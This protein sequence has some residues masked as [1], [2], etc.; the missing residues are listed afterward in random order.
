M[1]CVSE[2]ELGILWI[3]SPGL[4][5]THVHKT[6]LCYRSLKNITPVVLE[7]FNSVVPLYKPA[8]PVVCA[9]GWRWELEPGPS[10][11]GTEPRITEYGI[12]WAGRDPVESWKVQLKEVNKS[13]TSNNCPLFS[14][15][16]IRRELA[17]KCNYKFSLPIITKYSSMLLTLFEWALLLDRR[18]SPPQR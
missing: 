6:L 16:L 15:E 3:S 1:W 2:A 8:S 5:E 14:P 4:S 12:S 7:L 11:D 17:T 10:R 13:N 18:G 9:F